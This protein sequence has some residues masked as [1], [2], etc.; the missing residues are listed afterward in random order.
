MVLNKYI[1]KSDTCPCVLIQV[2]DTDTDTISLDSYIT[3][4]LPHGGTSSDSIKYVNAIT[5]NQ[6]KNY[7]YDIAVKTFPSQLTQTDPETGSTVPKTGVKYNWSFS[8]SG[9]SRVLTISFTGVTLTT[10]NKSTLQTACNTRFGS[11]KVVVQ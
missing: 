7:V 4:C 2:I 9:S 3:V 6:R 10:A 8:G 5:D 11:G 1:W